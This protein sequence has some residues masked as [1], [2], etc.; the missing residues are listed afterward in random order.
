MYGKGL[1]YPVS[2]NERI[3]MNNPQI[4]SNCKKLYFHSIS[5]FTEQSNQ[6]T[7]PLTHTKVTRPFILELSILYVWNAKMNNET[8][9]TFQKLRVLWG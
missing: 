9:P 1:S 7:H 4:P 6:L 8:V 5:T 2:K 3:G